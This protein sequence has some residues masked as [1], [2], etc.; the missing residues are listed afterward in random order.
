MK[1]N[2]LNWKIG[3]AAGFGIMATGLVFS[4]T[5]A[6]G[7]LHIFDYAEYPSLIRGGHNTY[8][9]KVDEARVN[10][11]DPRVDLLVALNA[12]SLPLHVS[13]LVPGAGIIYDPGVI[14]SEAEAY[15]VRGFKMFPVPLI[16]I[17]KEHGDVIMQ[18]TVALGASFALVKYP[19]SY[20]EGAIQDTFSGRKKKDTVAEANVA[21]ARAGY[22]HIEKQFSSIDFPIHLES[23]KNPKNPTEQLVVT[24]NDALALG[25]IQ[26]GCRMYVAYPMSP[27]S[28]ILHT[29]AAY[30]E[31]FG[32][33][34]KHAE[35]EISVANMAI[36]AGFAGVRSMVG[37]SG[38]GFSLM[39]EALGLA[40]IT[41][42]PVV[43]VNAQR[44]GPATGL[45]TW[46]EQ[47]DLRFVIHAAQGEFP[48]FVLAPGD[49]E[50]CFAA[51]GIAFNLAEK[52]QTPVIILLDKYLSES[53]ASCVPF[54]T[55]DVTIDRGEIAREE[56]LTRIE[57][58][59]RYRVTP[60]GI[61]P[62]ALPGTKGGIHIANSDEH[63]AY[64]FSEESSENRT[65]QMEK[66]LRKLTGVA[67]SLL[68]PKVT[69]RADARVTLIGW[70]STKGPIREAAR[71]L[72]AK[73]VSVRTVHLMHVWPFPTRSMGR[74]LKSAKRSVVIENNATGQLFGL[75]REMTGL[76]ADAKVLKFDG[77]PFHPGEI[78]ESI[79]EIE[80]THA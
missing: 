51:P 48:R 52:Y 33:V 49:V 23:S 31:R 56:E 47:A 37:T 4:K 75:I 61:S 11:H 25:A 77:R 45:P 17:A 63:D 32:I 44:P 19:F 62:R 35:D 3:G 26:A 14:G 15:R 53:H 54:N 70:G 68:Q 59:N 41:E 64:G 57:E 67:E 40:G 42:T 34:V 69:G 12:E 16:T 78:Q 6:R 20:L 27:S 72:E 5:C 2:I 66:R 73:G 79:Q 30:G 43:M 46:T 58:Y 24:G 21:A 50:E 1:K 60:S 18:N 22:E 39:V 13:E 7:G 10:A 9:V 55:A 8:Q 71:M 80:R 74:I 76:E 28:S 65:E 36:G 38:G 29:L